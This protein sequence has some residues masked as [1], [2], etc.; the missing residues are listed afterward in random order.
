VSF[1]AR[2]GQTLAIVGESGSG[3]SVTALSI[4]RLLPARVGRITSGSIRF[5][6]RELTDLP[7]A[8]IRAIR[9][10]EIGMIFQE[11]MTSLNPVHTIGAQISEVLLQH[12][13]LSGAAARER[14]LELLKMVGI[15]EPQRRINSHPHELS[16][17]M[18]QRVMIAM[19]LAC[20]PSLLI[21]DE[22]TTALDVTIQAQILD[23]MDEL[24]ARLGMAIIFIT[25]DLGVVAQMARDVVVMYAGQVVER[26]PVAEIFDRPRMP[27]TA[28]LI[29]SIPRLGRAHRGRRLP[30]IAGHV[31]ALSELG[32]GCRFQDRCAHA[33]P[34]CGQRSPELEQVNEEH[35]VRCHRWREL[36]LSTGAEA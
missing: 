31:P 26:G 22:P 32:A 12:E 33:A 18:R 34:I 30:T 7:E 25:H 4:T 6:G 29:A 1:T 15:A 10:R 23:L 9:G 2:S 21:A 13:A 36:Q 35:A 8:D 27:Y 14:T 28:G 11:P 19:A 24:Q 3:K 17:G 20:N 5:R 16:G